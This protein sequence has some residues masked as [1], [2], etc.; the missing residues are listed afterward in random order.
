MPVSQ[1]GGGLAGASQA[2]ID[3]I[4]GSGTYTKILETSELNPPGLKD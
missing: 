2:G 1:G 3:G 4:I